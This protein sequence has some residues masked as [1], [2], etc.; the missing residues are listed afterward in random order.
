MRRDGSADP[1]RLEPD[2]VGDARPSGGARRR[3]LPACSTRRR[4]WRRTRCRRGHPGGATRRAR[5]PDVRQMSAQIDAAARRASRTAS[6]TVRGATASPTWIATPGSGSV[7]RR[8]PQSTTAAHSIG[9]PLSGVAILEHDRSG[10]HGAQQRPSF[11][12]HAA[13]GEPGVGR[14][15]VAGAGELVAGDV[16]LGDEHRP[17]R[18]APRRA[19]RRSDRRSGRTRRSSPSAGTVDGSGADVG[20]VE[21]ERVVVDR[22]TGAVPATRPVACTTTT[23][24]ARRRPHLVR[25]RARW[26]RA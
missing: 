6:W 7:G 13:L 2:R 20:D 17:R 23:P 18:R 11:D 3:W 14:G 12:A 22:R 26:R 8:K 25:S 15:E 10:A 1:A 21:H 9:A 16:V 19:R 4:R 24:P 5:R